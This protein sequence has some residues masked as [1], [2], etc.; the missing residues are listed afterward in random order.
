MFI[1]TRLVLQEILKGFYAKI[2]GCQL[3]TEK[4][5]GVQIS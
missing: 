2:K 4:I 3:V 5:L 1:T